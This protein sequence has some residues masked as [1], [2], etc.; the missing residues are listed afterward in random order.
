MLGDAGGSL[1]PR[2]EFGYNC[3]CVDKGSV[4]IFTPIY[5]ADF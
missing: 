3:V 5:D 2:R 1:T 4:F